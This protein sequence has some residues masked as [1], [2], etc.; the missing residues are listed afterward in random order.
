MTKQLLDFVVTDPVVLLIVENRD[1]HVQVR[2]DFAQSAC[3]PKRDSEQPAR[4]EHPHP[5]V[6]LMSRRFDCVAEG[7]EQRTEELFAAATRHRRESRS[8]G[9]VGGREVGFPLAAQ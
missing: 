5:L 6:E 8:S 3:C 4:P 9:N 2:Q 1:Q 7:L